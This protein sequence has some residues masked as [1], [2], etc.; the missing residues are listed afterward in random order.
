VGL[1]RAIPLL[2]V[3]VLALPALA[4][5]QCSTDDLDMNGVPDVCPAGTNYIEG[6]AA[7]ETLRGTNGPDCIFGLGGADTIRG[8]NGDDYICAGD[9]DDDI[10]GGGD[11]DQIFGEAGNDTVVGNPGNDFIDGGDGNDI[12]DGSAGDDSVNGG[13]GNDDIQGSAGADALSGQ[14]G[15]DT[16]SGG[17]GNDSLSGGNGIDTLDGGGGTNTCVEEVPGTSERLTNCDAVTYAAVSGFDAIRTERG[18]RVAWDTTTEVGAVAFRLWRREASGALHWVGEI[19]AA[20]EGSPHGARYFMRD[21]TRPADGLVEYVIEERTVS[22][23]SVQYGPFIESPAPAD[24][25]D[26]LVQSRTS[27][28]RLPHRVELRHL[29]RPA[30]SQPVP[31]FGRKTAEL[32]TAAVLEV[33]RGG[34]IEV[35]A[36][37][38]AQALE[39]SREGVVDL[40]RA[41]GLHLRLRGESIAWHSVDGGA[42]LR[43]VAPE[44]SSPFSSRHRY[45]LSV[46]DG[47]TMEARALVQGGAVEPHTFIETKRFEEN[48]FAGPSGGPDPRQDLFFWHALS[49]E[50]QVV[51]PVS[52][53]ALSGSGA[54]E[55]RVYVHGATEHPE[56]PHRVELHWNGQSLGVFDLLGRTRHV[57]VMP[58]GGIPAE[59]EN[60]LVVQQHVAGEAPPVLYVDAVEVDYVREAAADAPVFRFGGAEEGE[61]S[62]TGLTSET[63][64]VYDVTDPSTPRHYGE[65]PLDETGRL[66]FIAEGSDLRFLVAAPDGVSAPLEVR[67]HFAAGLR[68]TAQGAD[69]V[70]IAASHLVADAQRLAD[71][72]EA[73][74][75]RVLLVDIDDV[76]WE[77]AGGEPDPLAVRDFLSFAKQEWE[78]A[79]RFAALV[80]KGTLDYRDLMGLG[81]NWLPPALA[82]T[83]GGLFPSD[84]MLGDVVGDDGVPEIAIG[85]LPI[86]TAEELD[87]II[88]AIQAFEANHES[89]AALFAADDSTRDDFAAAMRLL[90]GWTTP[91]RTQEI[92][93][94]AETLENARARLL[95]MWEGRLSWVS[96]VGHSGLDRIA[97]EGLLTSADVP[98]LAEMQSTPVVLGWT[99]NMVRFD[100]PGFFSLGEQ[101]LTEGTSAGVFSAT[102]WSNHVDTDALRTAFTEAVFA[103]DAETIGEAMI[104]AHQAA[105]D[106]P[107]PLHRVY[108]LLGDPALRLRAPKAQPD[109][110]PVPEIDPTPGGHPGEPDGVPGVGEEAPSFGSGCEIAPPGTQRAP[111]GL[112]LL[113]LGLVLV[114]RRSRA[115][116]QRRS[117]LH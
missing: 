88:D 13:A 85:R 73:D 36:T 103:S 8:R 101:L 71:L 18:V 48:V 1:L 40:I 9:G 15:D 30:L 83:E 104:R 95:S 51:I 26:R 90:T 91:E 113:V 110:D 105:S 87:R 22:G 14:D 92:D 7:G 64:H 47:V 6:T 84:S 115:L 39:T 69:Y 29:A 32:P 89:M 10:G 76:Y 34:V 96:Y 17:G 117:H 109:P 12:L 116:R 19:A 57:I 42:A 54:E 102:G 33:D 20:P 68:S 41:G 37:V 66:S 86:T 70:I 2:I 53:P 23:G 46:E 114:F 100:I 97:T 98:A 67:P 62:V 16:L 28:S 93:L 24:A 111:F 80:G 38:I 107:V 112:G 31:S 43:F 81:G 94:N 49:S 52:L 72:R 50:A 61:H 11:D 56:Q 75:Y 45:L 35:D 108:M 74:G 25:R 27:Q 44:V 60:E 5:A 3:A 55:L 79:P 99:C 106:A 78:T 4:G 82:P 21:E 63:A 65:V 59:L 58:V 77:F